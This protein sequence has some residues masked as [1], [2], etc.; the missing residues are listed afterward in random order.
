M[1]LKRITALTP[2]IEG[3]DGEPTYEYEEGQRYSANQKCAHNLFNLH[4]K[5]RTQL[6]E[7]CDAYEARWQLYKEWLHTIDNPIYFKIWRYCITSTF[8]L[9]A[10]PPDL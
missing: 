7:I 10:A 2:V 9:L 3:D 4:W 5:P 6:R 8:I 1:V